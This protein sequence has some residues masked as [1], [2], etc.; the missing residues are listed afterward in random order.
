MALCAD[1]RGI[2]GVVGGEPVW[3]R[4]DRF[5]EVA[6]GLS[7]GGVITVYHRAGQ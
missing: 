2:G 3:S 5:R 1:S 7:H 4:V 6:V